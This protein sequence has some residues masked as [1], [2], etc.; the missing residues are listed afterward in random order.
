MDRYCIA[1]YGQPLVIKREKTPVPKG[2]EVLIEVIGCGLCHSDVHLW[3]GYFDLGDG[4]KVDLSRSHTL[5]FTLG[6]E[7][8]G[9]VVNWGDN[10]TG[11]KTGAAV[12]IYPW[13][14]CGNCDVCANGQENLC[15]RPENLGVNNNGGFSTH[16]IVPHKK[17][18]F[19][20]DDLAPSLAATYACSG[21]TAFSALKKAAA[22]VKG[23]R[24][25]II[26]AGGVGLA[27]INIAQSIIE[28]EIFVAE[29]DETK[30]NAAIKAGADAVINPAEKDASRNLSKRLGGGFPVVI[31]FVGSEETVRFGF[32]SLRASGQ[33]IIVGLYGGSIK[34]STP[35]FPLKNITVSG[36]YVGSLSEMT[37]LMALV[38]SNSIMPMPIIEK[39][40]HY[41]NDALAD[42][43]SGD[44]IGRMVLKPDIK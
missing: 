5:P 26:G 27:A 22:K 43:A 44:V 17:Y 35:I 24:L 12:V 8:V 3:E 16:V 25:L 10:A 28:A 42:L 19:T 11:L 18:L 32:D 41:I 29:I 14:G 36:S 33:L 40:L 7:I 2:S 23:S 21:L 20:I 30:R 9:R 15:S 34:L 39:P 4:N 6:H 37:E 38:K 31:D 1:S 13:I